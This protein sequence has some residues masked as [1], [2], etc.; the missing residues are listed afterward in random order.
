MSFILANI[1]VDYFLKGGPIMWPILVAFLVAMIVVLQRSL[2]WLSLRR[3]THS[4]PLGESFDAIAS[5]EF[6]KALSLTDSPNDPFLRTVHDGL[7]HAH[8]SL[9]GAMTQAQ[10]PQ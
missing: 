9:L 10:P 6:D 8:S 7:V 2:W 4:A 1:I 3:R 5:G